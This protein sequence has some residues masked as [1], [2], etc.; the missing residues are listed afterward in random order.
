VTERCPLAA[1]R[2]RPGSGGRIASGTVNLLR[3]PTVRTT[4]A[5]AT[6]LAC[7][8][9]PVFLFGALSDLIRGD[10]DF[11]EAGVGA[12]V[13]VFF[14]AAGLGAVPAGRVTE[15]VGA[16]VAMVLG[17]SVAGLASLGIGVLTQRW[18]H[19]AVL[20]ALAGSSVGLI[21]TGGARAFADVV[22]PRRQGLAFGIKEAS[23]PAASMLAG[24]AVPLLGLTIG[25]RPTFGLGLLLIPFVWLILPPDVR[26]TATPVATTETARPARSTL[27]LIAIGSAAGTGAA[28]ATAS[29]L[30]P[31]ATN[32]GLSVGFAGTLLAV[33]SGLS[34]VARI[35]AGHGADTSRRSELLVVALMLG[36]GALGP[37][38]LALD[39][40]AMAIAG[41][42][43]TLGAGW[44]W[45]GLVF[46]SAVRADPSAPAAAAGIVLAGLST[47]GAL[48]P[49]AFGL[50]ASNAG[51][52][53]AWW[54]TAGAMLVGTGAI[55]T[56]DRQRRRTRPPPGSVHQVRPPG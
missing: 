4:A 1:I 28:T 7:A 17:C 50:L 44:G 56:A 31:A 30:V 55:G 46:L 19:A 3:R 38:L 33:G 41:G 23:V 14:V 48:G 12:G 39:G 49:I 47:G 20:L 42:L 21:D 25:W 51:Y 35:V 53:A 6:A 2:G 13:T 34:I 10:L 54:A 18:W 9:V 32:A 27:V 26:A 5:T 45:T 11:G 8:L 52:P 36:V 37:L 24:A 22:P 16:R 29:F 43:L 40:P 15:R